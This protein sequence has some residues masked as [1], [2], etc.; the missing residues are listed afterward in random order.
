MFIFARL[1]HVYQYV[2]LDI[3]VGFVMCATTGRTKIKFTI[4]YK[5]KYWHI[6]HKNVCHSCEK[7]TLNQSLSK[8]QEEC[9]TPA[10]KVKKL[11]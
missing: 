8:H 7:N 11:L 1:L 10:M 5:F 9:F 2:K 4:G 3:H 6:F